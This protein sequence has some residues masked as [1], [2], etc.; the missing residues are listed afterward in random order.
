MSPPAACEWCLFQ[1]AIGL[2]LLYV[3]AFSPDQAKMM[4]R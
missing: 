4:K 1:V 3:A 2:R